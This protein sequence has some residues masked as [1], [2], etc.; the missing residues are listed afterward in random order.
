VTE[1]EI[2]QIKRYVEEKYPEVDIDI[3][4]GKQPVYSFLIGVE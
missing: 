1:K 4:D 3:H 2:D